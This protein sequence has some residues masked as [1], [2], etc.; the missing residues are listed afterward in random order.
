MHALR[1]V[2]EELPFEVVALVLDA[3]REEPRRRD[4]LLL[5]APV[6]ELDFDFRRALDFAEQVRHGQAA[7][8]IDGFAFAICD[9]GIDELDEAVLVL[10]VDDDHA[11]GLADL[12]RGEADAV[13]LVHRL[14]HV[15][16]ELPQALVDALDGR[17]MLL[18]DGVARLF[19][20]E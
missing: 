17:T 3:A 12:R 19:D 14:R 20:I 4:V 2:D 18:Q 10:H 5:A 11:D 15:V 6:Q 1:N 9:D 8:R 13:R 7:F 16:Q